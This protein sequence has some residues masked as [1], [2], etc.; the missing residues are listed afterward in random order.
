MIIWEI[1]P[2]L[3]ELFMHPPSFPV[4]GHGDGCIMVWEGFPSVRQQKGTENR[5][6]DIRQA[7]VKIFVRS[8]L[9]S[10]ET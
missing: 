9:S 3:Y 10:E 4:I 6:T 2:Q 5:G 1:V 7:G 8:P